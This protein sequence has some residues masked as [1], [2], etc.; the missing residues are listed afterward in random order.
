MCFYLRSDKPNPNTFL[1]DEVEVG[2]KY[3]VVFTQMYGLYRYR[4]GDVVEITG[5]YQNCPKVKVLYR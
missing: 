5:F 3:E 4:L 1:V 2:E